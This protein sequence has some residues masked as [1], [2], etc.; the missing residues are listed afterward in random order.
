[1]M[2]LCNV[3]EADLQPNSTTGTILPIAVNSQLFIFYIAGS[4]EAHW[5]HCEPAVHRCT[6]SLRCIVWS[7]ITVHLLLVD[8]Q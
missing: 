3:L 6:K 8:S 7:G 5:G 2:V 4:F 1:M